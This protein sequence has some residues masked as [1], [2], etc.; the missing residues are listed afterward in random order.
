MRDMKLS[1]TV[2]HNSDKIPS[3]S[4]DEGW[5]ISYRLQYVA[6]NSDHNERCDQI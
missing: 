2:F 4:S 3:S 6:N 5:A 1:Y